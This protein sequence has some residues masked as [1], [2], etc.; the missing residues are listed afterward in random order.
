[1]NVSVLQVDCCKPILG[2][3]AFD[4]APAHQ[5][6]ER[7]L[8]QSLVQDSP[9]QDWLLTT[10]LGYDE[11]RAK[12]KQITLSLRKWEQNKMK[13]RILLPALHREKEWRCSRHL[14]RKSKLQDL[15]VARVRA[16]LSTSWMTWGLAGTWGGAALLR[17]ARRDGLGVDSAWGGAAQEDAGGRPRRWA[18]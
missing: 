17:E 13:H 11:V 7:E 10:F 4:N 5:H 9:I 8:V 2:L 3:D 15:R 18:D 1:M 12:E 16:A 14:L 6:L